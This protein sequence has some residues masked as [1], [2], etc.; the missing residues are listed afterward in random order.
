MH[1]WLGVR[2][3]I[4]QSVRGLLGDGGGLGQCGSSR[5]GKQSMSGR[6][7]IYFKGRSDIT[8]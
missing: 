8:C 2:A 1:G 3:E 6:I 7:W 4:R 5:R